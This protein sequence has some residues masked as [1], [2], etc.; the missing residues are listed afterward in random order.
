MKDH[1]SNTLNVKNLTSDSRTHGY[2][3][4]IATDF[5][6]PI[7]I[8]LGHLA[9]WAEKNLANNTNIYD[10]LV[11]CYDTLEA[12]TDYFPYF[13][14]RQIERMINNA[15][16]KGLV[17]KG[18]Y[19]QTRYDRTVWYAL[20]P[21]AYFYFPHLVTE[22]Y[23][24]RLCSSISPNGEMEITEWGNRFPHYVTTIPNTT[25][26]TDPDISLSIISLFET[27]W[28]LYPVK[29]GKKACFNK[30]KR[31]GDTELY[32]KIIKNL[33]MQIDLDKEWREGF[34]PS[35]MAY[36]RDQRWEDEIKPFFGIGPRTV[37]HEELGNHFS[38]VD[39]RIRDQEEDSI[40][41]ATEFLGIG[42]TIQ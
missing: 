39:K 38:N 21:E 7:S 18:N 17:V 2:H 37:S 13:T 14:K 26:N 30:W 42:N 41:R 11:W 24:N 25:P 29:K 1:K 36:L 8:F 31:L 3:V 6:L 40:R 22:K 23:I 10:G 9:F 4:G 32:N 19:N 15:I 12:L 20:T 27:F 28:N 16:E 33:N 34:I 35:A 5:S